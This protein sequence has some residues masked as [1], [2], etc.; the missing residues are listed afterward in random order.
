MK[1][2]IKGLCLFLCLTLSGPLCAKEQNTNQFFNAARANKTLDKLSIK[3][4][5]Q[6]LNV[7]DLE[8]A[9]KILTTLQ[10][11]ANQCIVQVDN[12]LKEIN[13]LWTEAKI[14]TIKSEGQST[15][16][17]T[18]VQAYLNKKKEKLNEWKSECRLFS[19]RAKEAIDAYSNTIKKLHTEALLKTK[20]TVWQRLSGTA[21]LSKEIHAKFNGELF[22]ERSG[23]KLFN[24]FTAILFFML[25][26]IGIFMAIKIRS[27]LKQYLRKEPENFPQRL[28]NSLVASLGKYRYQIIIFSITSLF[29][30]LQGFRYHDLNYLMLISYGLL[31]FSLFLASAYFLFFP[32][33]FE[34]SITSLSKSLAKTLTLRLKIFAHIFLISYVIFIL[35]HDQS[36][37]TSAIDLARTFFLTLV[38]ISLISILWLINRLPILLQEYRVSRFIFSSI[39]TFFLIF[40]I[41]AEW[42]GYQ[43]LVTYILKGLMF[44]IAAG[45][46]AWLLHRMVTVLL[47]HFT[48]DT[49][50]FQEYIRDALGVKRYE[51]MAELTL[52]QLALYILIWGGF[53]LLLLKVWGISETNFRILTKSLTKGFKI[54]NFDI[55]PVQILSAI[56]FFV[57]SFL[58]IR[59]LKTTLARRKTVEARRGAQ[60]A[61]ASIVAYTGIIIITL[62]ALII[63]GVNFAGLAIIAGA[64][65]VGIGFGL[66]SI[67]NNFV[68]GLILLIERPIKPGD[69]VIIGDKE[70]YVKKISIRSTQIK[71]LDYFDVIVPNSEIVSQQVTNLMF[72]DFYGRVK[73]EIGVAYGSDTELVKKL[74]FDIASNHPEVVKDDPRY[75][76]WVGFVNFGE[77]ALNFKL[78][79]A[80]RNVNLRYDVLSELNLQID[81]AFKEHDISIAFPQRDVHIKDWTY[82]KEISKPPAKGE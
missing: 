12:N 66:Q 67:V 71:T 48:N 62:V 56:L 53:G 23:L 30:T 40:I 76:I 19:I 73:I 26:G 10:N 17:L 25:L 3:L 14:D 42:L 6:N 24:W 16:E 2:F 72:H 28:K 39:L 21:Q 55:I 54:A 15:K 63:A 49:S 61:L 27:P 75:K 45:F 35:F 22:F 20:P 57:I 52:L 70:G 46:I 9:A 65:S 34:K 31:I 37:S 4:S 68:S 78:F 59:W 58:F 74:L 50:S 5:I 60:E 29:L 82:H 44:T 33:Q 11:D 64:L 47:D 43:L 7:N 36:F 51:E 8:D 69:R 80:V 38:A 13:K 81:K 32:Y 79:C 18:S 77:N 1:L 41:V